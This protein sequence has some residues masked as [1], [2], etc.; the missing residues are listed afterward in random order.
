MTGLNIKG[1]AFHSERILAH[2]DAPCLLGN[3][4]GRPH[5]AIQC[6]RDKALPAIDPA[7]ASPSRGAGS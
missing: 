6:S 2:A 7:F 4:R 1:D 3:L 5:G